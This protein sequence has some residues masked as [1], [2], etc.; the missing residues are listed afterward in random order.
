MFTWVRHKFRST[1]KLRKQH[2]NIK[3]P[4]NKPPERGV[5]IVSIHTREREREIEQEER[6]KKD[7]ESLLKDEKEGYHLRPFRDNNRQITITV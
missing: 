3:A 4:I 2:I 6:R 7:P 5:S 1:P